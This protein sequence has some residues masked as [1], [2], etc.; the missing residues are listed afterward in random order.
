MINYY[1]KKGLSRSE[2]PYDTV[3]YGD[4]NVYPQFKTYYESPISYIQITEYGMIL[5]ESLE[6]IKIFKSARSDQGRCIEYYNFVDECSETSFLPGHGTA[7]QITES[8]GN[9]YEV[10]DNPGEKKC[11]NVYCQPLLH[12][13]E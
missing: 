12:A 3:Y 6:E 9:H 10:H 7:A 8:C 2:W 1:K 5:D 4:P 13:P 11:Y